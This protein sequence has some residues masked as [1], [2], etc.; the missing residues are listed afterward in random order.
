MERKIYIAVSGCKNGF[1]VFYTTPGLDMRMPGV[2][3]ALTDMRRYL[4]ISA[5]LVDYYA[6]DYLHGWRIYTVYRSSI[7]SA[8]A[9]GAFIAVS[10]II[11][12]ELAVRNPRRLLDELMASYFGEYYHPQFG[13]PQPGKP[14]SG[15]RLEQILLSHAADITRPPLYITPAAHSNVTLPLYL[16][17]RELAEADDVFTDPY[18]S[19]YLSGSKLILFPER[20]LANPAA[21]R[22]AFNTDIR[23]VRR[24]EGP[25]DRLIGQLSP[26][27]Q[28]G[29]VMRRFLLNGIDYTAVYSHVCLRP[30]DNIQVDIQRPDLTLV[31]FQGPVR[32]ALAEHLL[33][34]RGK[35]YFFG[36]LPYELFF[37][38]SGISE[39]VPNSNI[40]LPSLRIPSGELLPMR[41][42][43][44]QRG[45]VLIRRQAMSGNLVFSDGKE[46]LP[47]LNI[48]V[49]VEGSNPA[50]P[51]TVEMLSCCYTVSVMPK[52]G[53]LT[54]RPRYP[55]RGNTRNFSIP[56]QM[57]GMSLSMAIPASIR[58]SELGFAFGNKRYFPDERTSQLL[59]VSTGGGLGALR[60]PLWVW[61]AGGSAIV[62]IA[63][64]LIMLLLR[65]GD[66]KPQRG[67]GAE[68]VVPADSL[69]TPQ[70]LRPDPYVVFFKRVNSAEELGKLDPDSIKIIADIYDSLHPQSKIEYLPFTAD[71]TPVKPDPKQLK[72]IFDDMMMHKKAIEQI[73]NEKK[74]QADELE[75]A[76]N[77]G[78]REYDQQQ[79][80]KAKQQAEK[81]KQ[82]AEKAKQQGNKK[83]GKKKNSSIKKG[84]DG[85]KPATVHDATGAGPAAGGGGGEGS[86]AK[87]TEQKQG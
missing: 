37:N 17:V 46:V 5:P 29:T 56:L 3:D 2:I 82:Q 79:A 80:E 26:L 78:R 9:S 71:G 64:L 52:G 21:E 63:V 12:D 34:A 28:Q 43:N 36:F 83:A 8:G 57:S 1:S 6:V 66:S 65:G 49:Q 86:S 50:A 58:V 7:D 62:L 10:L 74:H 51:V 68:V 40:L 30:D 25:S 4:R 54:L 18:H 72:L 45:S 76:V 19:V 35:G 16:P 31:S 14:E 48:P 15:A 67:G 11:P 41:L 22:V 27:A 69:A 24:A 87:T 85:G 55:G 77:E 59:P 20:M 73:I 42:V 13:T 38:L 60:L 39:S 47:G 84:P 61:I 75:E 32:R 33:V 44:L 23:T 70:D 53:P 81:A